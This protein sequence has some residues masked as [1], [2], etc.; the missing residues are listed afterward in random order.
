MFTKTCKTHTVNGYK[1]VLDT[2][3]HQLISNTYKTKTYSNWLHTCTRQN[4]TAIGCKDLQHKTYS[5]CQILLT[6]R[7]FNGRRFY[8]GDHWVD[9]A[10]GCTRWTLVGR[11]VVIRTG[12]ATKRPWVLGVKSHRTRNTL[13]FTKVIVPPRLTQGWRQWMYILISCVFMLGR[14]T[15][16]KYI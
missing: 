1:Y 16:V 12:I 14:F 2:T 11:G 8:V 7:V 4:L 13:T 3:I 10:R 9:G 5:K 15:N 6:P